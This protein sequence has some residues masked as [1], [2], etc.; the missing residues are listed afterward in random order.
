MTGRPPSRPAPARGERGIALVMAIVVL[1]VVTVLGSM[2]MQSLSTERKISGH[3]L[4]ATRALSIAE[5]GIAEAVSR[6]R[7]GEIRLDE[8]DPASAAQIF[9][10]SAGSL[11]AMSGDTTAF[12]SLQPALGRIEYSTPGRSPNA[13]T[14]SFRTNARGDSIVRYDDALQPP[15]NT[16]T[17]FAV[18]RVLATGIVGQDLARVQAE[19]VPKPVH[20]T[21]PAA[22]TSQVAVNLG[23]GFGLCGYRHAAATAFGH[24]AEGRSGT[25]ACSADEVGHGDVPAVWS[26]GTV[27]NTGAVLAG[28]PLA[29]IEGGTAFFSGPAEA[30]GLSGAEL[31]TI[32]GTSVAAVPANVAGVVWLDDDGVVGNRGASHTVSGLQGE[33]FLYV[34]GDLTLTG[35]TQF[36]GLVYVEG[37]LQSSA[38]GQ[39]VGGLV[40]RGRTGGGCTLTT[41]PSVLYSPDAMNGPVARALKTLVT[42]SWREVR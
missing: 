36:R 11:P 19:V 22:V 38:T 32:L 2:L 23:G 37:D 29:R 9:L 26:G 31:T 27:T 8:T 21:L 34:D 20:A 28:S 24:G 33:G 10:A 12:A 3:G 14:I 30:L 42:L 40:V 25:P 5:A 4:R 39:I 7:S 15:Y 16:V 6:V 18:L 17:G 1:L 13:L 35:V 41:G